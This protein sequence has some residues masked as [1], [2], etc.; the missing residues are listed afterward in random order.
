MDFSVSPFFDDYQN[1]AKPDNYH[2]ILFIPG[3]AVQARELTQI[4]SILQEQ[5]K[6]QGDSLFQ[7][8][9]VVIPGHVF[10]DNTVIALKLNST[11]GSTSADAVGA[12]LI[13][14]NI[15]GSSGVSATVMYFT[16]STSTDPSTLYIKYNGA[17]GAVHTFSSGEVISSAALGLSL[18]I[19]SSNT[20][21]VP[22]S[23]C[24][25]S[26]GIYYV[27]GFF[28]GVN[29]QTI[30]LDKY[31][32]TP[33][34]AV[35]L[36]FV[37]NVVT[38]SQ[39]PNLFDN[40]LGSQNYAAPGASRYQI[41]L[42][43]TTR[44]YDYSNPAGQT[45]VTF[46]PL[47]RVQNGNIQY[48]LQDTQYSQIES[49]LA[50][51][52]YD[53][54]GDYIVNPFIIS[55]KNYRSNNRGQW[56]TSTP[57]LTGDIVSN[58]GLF[59]TAMNNGYSGA[60]APSVSYGTV[61][62]GGMYWLQTNSPVY[63]NGLLNLTSTNLQ[64]HI[65][66]ETQISIRST[67]GKAY[68]QGF[69]V[70]VAASQSVLGYK[71]RDIE[72]KT[73]VQLYTP[74]GSYL[75]VTNVTGSIDTT[76]MTEVNLINSASSVIG[77]AYVT[78]MEYVSGTIGTS[79]AVYNLYLIDIQLQAG[80]S[81]Y[82]SVVTVS[83]TTGGLFSSI[84]ILTPIQ[85]SGFVS[86]SGT[87]S[88][89]VNGKGTL[90]T[91]EVK[92]GDTIQ[93]N[94][95]SGVVLSIQSDVELTLTA[96]FGTIVTNVPIF[97]LEAILN[98]V[99]S[100]IQK[101]PHSFI[102]SVR[103]SAGSIDTEYTTYKTFTFTASSSGYSLT[104][105]ST[106]QYFNGITGHI[107]TDTTT[108][109]IIN[110]AY[111]LSTDALTLTITGLTA[112]H[113]Y[114]L[115]ALIVN[116][117]NGAKEKVKTLTTRTI[118]VYN[119]SITDDLGN[120]ISS[121]GLNPNFTSQNI[122]LTK[123]DAQ[124]LVQVKM[125]G[126]TSSTYSASGETDVT[127]WFK[128]VQNANEEFYDISYIQRVSGIVS[129]PLKIVFQYFEHSTGDYF[130]V[131]SYSSIPYNQIPIEVHGTS[132]YYMRDCLDFR[133]KISD[134]RSGF[135]N[136]G[137]NVGSP[138]YNGNVLSTSYSFYLPRIDVVSLTPA[139]N[140]EYIEG[141]SSE[142]PTVPLVTDN[143]L[144]LAVLTLDPYTIDPSGSSINITTTPHKRYTM[145]DIA[146]IDQR[147][148]NVEYYVSLNLLEQKTN[149]LQ[150]YDQNGLPRYKNGFIADPFNNT[151]VGD[152]S[153]PDFRVSIDTMN[154]YCRPLLQISAINLLET[155]GSTDSS[156]NANGYK[157]TN[158]FVT[159]PYSESAMIS[160]TLATRTQNINPFAAY[161]WNGTLK[162]SPQKDFWFDAAVYTFTTNTFTTTYNYNWHNFA[163]WDGGAEWLIGSS[164]T[165]TTNK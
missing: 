58:N 128:L 109:N 149:S 3:N 6:R 9:T 138:L 61:S 150:I 51:R 147:L 107:I 36:E 153:S 99:G 47:L 18:Q 8:G 63:N 120:P 17:N 14:T 118:I 127:S 64:D 119:G 103:T 129:Y 39:D 15:L 72:Q 159:L 28:V 16:A 23:I 90:F 71:A 22:S 53:E 35:G 163:F 132:T 67:A 20:A 85:L 140:L 41:I 162:I 86:V 89:I 101:F 29:A 40:A 31:D 74:T 96:N 56:T 78:H 111:S 84:A 24:S 79:G 157:V 62:D 110:A 19:K 82:D 48:L 10:Y 152:T 144:Q 165:T 50:R 66:A 46:I 143:S 106:N 97:S 38:A 70:N 133:N 94:G 12:S 98:R 134:D 69:E 125:S 88:P 137:A 142:T 52:T 164:S 161:N 158:N 5:I 160:Q 11:Y 100:Y 115:N 145:S 21:V 49:M 154:Q 136:S 112:T 102:Q 27:N 33:T 42:N 139:G 2:R 123:A 44:N 155:T 77:T 60:T 151:L 114:V 124:K 80:L 116:S 26:E 30:V 13:G 113:T 93:I 148:S 135:T 81:F 55:I 76:T 131:N 146:D 45:L 54:A 25:I 68:V 73:G 43:L 141:T 117:A 1:N 126:P 104:L 37:E 156:R 34:L 65:N 92:I 83:S 108:G 59:Y 105:G 122:Y 75:Q 57:Y 7:N 91:Q 121:T 4:Q 95:T 32:S 130:T 87:T